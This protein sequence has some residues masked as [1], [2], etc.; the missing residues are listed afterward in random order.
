[1]SC[2]EV[3]EIGAFVLRGNVRLDQASTPRLA[4]WRRLLS[5]LT[6]SR[7]VLRSSFHNPWLRYVCLGVRSG[8]GSWATVAGCSTTH[9]L[10]PEITLTD[11]THTKT[12]SHFHS[13]LLVAKRDG[14]VDSEVEVV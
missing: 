8:F 2:H 12:P 9:T 6:T 14:G 3:V 7:D 10:R 5:R 4:G 1:M 13:Y 11:N